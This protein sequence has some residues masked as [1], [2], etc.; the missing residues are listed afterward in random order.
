MPQISVKIT[1]LAQI[2]AA[3]SKAPVKMTTALNKAIQQSIFTIERDSKINTPVDTG[4]LRASHRRMFSTLRGEIGTNTEYDMFVHYGTRYMKARPYLLQA[5]Q[6]NDEKIQGFFTDA[7][8]K[9]LDDIARE[10]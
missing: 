2:R 6:T 1:N 10:V 7:V 8:Q 4:R 5:A 3:F 9:V